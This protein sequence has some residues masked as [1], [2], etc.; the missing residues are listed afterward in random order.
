MTF[1]APSVRSDDDGGSPRCSTRWFEAGSMPYGHLH[2]PFENR[3]RFEDAY[4][5]P[6]HRRRARPDRGAGSTRSMFSPSRSST[7]RPSA[8]A[9][10]TGW[11]STPMVAR[12]RRASKNY[13][14]PEEILEEQGA[15][16]LRAY[17]VNSPVLRAEPLRFNNDGV[18]EVVRTV[19][20][21]LWNTYSF[22]TTYAEADGVTSTTTWPQPRPWRIEARTRPL[23]PLGVAELWS[24]TST[25]RWRATTS[26]MSCR[27][28]SVSSRT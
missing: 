5:G 25:G 9:S 1:P 6:V 16:A 3:E 7:A 22:F 2:Y 24:T 17:L 10:S 12:C 18:R 15:D 26:S 21:P 14:D 4:P 8:T 11:S 19:L 28:S 13:T 23:D 20:L 27:R